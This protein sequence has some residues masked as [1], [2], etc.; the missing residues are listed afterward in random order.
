MPGPF[1]VRAGRL[2]DGTGADVVSNAVIVVDGERIAAVG[3]AGDVPVPPG[4]ET[5][6]L[7]DR[8]VMP[9]L[10]DAHSHASIVPGLGDQMAQLCQPVEQQLL[11]AVGNLR[12]DLRS[13]TTTMRLMAGKRSAPSGWVNWTA[14]L[15]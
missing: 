6:D 14:G 8:F 10:V 3:R 7:G 1:V 2:F 15:L 11:R 5:I 13:G 4:A 9:G 12:R